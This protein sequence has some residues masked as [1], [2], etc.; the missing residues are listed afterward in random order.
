[1][2]TISP[3]RPFRR[4]AAVGPVVPGRQVHQ[5]F[6]VEDGN[7]E[8]LRKALGDL[9]H[10]LRIG[11]VE[12]GAVR[13][14]VGGVACRQC[15]DQRLLPFARAG[16]KGL[17]LRK[18]RQRRLHG[19]GVHRRIDVGAEHERLGPEA[20]GA[21]RIEALGCPEAPPGFGMIEAV[22]ER[23]AF[24]EV[25]LRIGAL[26]RD[27]EGE[28]AKIAPERRGRSPAIRWQPHAEG[29]RTASIPS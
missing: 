1:M 2:L 24:V 15:L 23:Q 4:L 18:R 3:V 16:R 12:G 13:G 27:R 29:R 25:A 6:R 17:S 9:L 10:G 14:W 8:I 11:L 22:G 26:G 21:V 19:R 5:R 7:V 28:R 20:H